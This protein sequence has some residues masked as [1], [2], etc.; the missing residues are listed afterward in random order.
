MR[1]IMRLLP[2]NVIARNGFTFLVAIA[3]VFFTHMTVA[4]AQPYEVDVELVLAVDVSYSMDE[5][6]LRVQRAG[7]VSALT[8]PQVLDA[9]KMGLLGRIA[10][11]YLEWGGAHEQSILAEWHVINDKKSAIAFAEKVQN[12]P[13]QR[14]HNTSIASA[15]ET[16][17]NL[18]E[19]NQYEGLRKVIDVSG[20][21]TNNHGGRVIMA[22][23][24][25][26]SKGIV[27]NGL[28]LMMKATRV[29]RTRPQL[30][31]YYEACVIGGPGSFAIPVMSTDDFANAI[32]TKLV[33][34]I[35]GLTPYPPDRPRP[36]SSWTPMQCEG[37]PGR[38]AY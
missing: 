38:F 30:D 5:E 10:V 2:P 18:I 27:V 35:A 4:K 23:N 20:D 24:Y 36:V 21:G 13:Y 12:A 25:A 26:I 3:L 16:A 6:E 14:L 22:R 7:Y 34:E 28:P 8:S 17:S 11:T 37:N 32:R 33:L 29:S 1:H 31:L 9:I 15:L 19:T